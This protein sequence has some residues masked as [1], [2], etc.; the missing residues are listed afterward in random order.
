MRT[1]GMTTITVHEDRDRE[2]RV[3]CERALRRLDRLVA[4]RDDVLLRHARELVRRAAVLAATQERR[5][6]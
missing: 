4:E 5:A 6:A 3:S 1:A 2:I